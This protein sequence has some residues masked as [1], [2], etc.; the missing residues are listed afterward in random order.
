MAARSHIGIAICCLAASAALAFSAAGQALAAPSAT[1]VH[2]SRAVA[3][4]TAMT[5]AGAGAGTLT[6]SAGDASASGG[7][8]LALSSA[9]A[10]V[11]TLGAGGWQVQSSAPRTGWTTG[12]GAT[13]D[14]GQI[15]MPGFSTAGWLPVR[16]DDAGAVGTEVEALL[17]NGVC[18]DHPSLE[19]VN[20][21]ADDPASVF[22][23]NN[24]QRCFGAPMTS[25]GADTDPLFD[26]PWWFRTDFTSSLRP[27]QDAKLVINGVVGQADLWVNGTE[28]AT[29]ATVEGDYN[30]YTFDVTNL[31]RPG[32]NSLAFEMFP[33]NP[34]AMFTLDDVD[35]NQIPPDNNTGIQFPVELHV[36][37]AL[38]ISNSYVTQD[39]AADLS[40]ASLTVHADVT[41]NS[42]TTQA[43]LV[44]AQISPPGGG[45][46]ISVTR[47]VRL[48]G[49]ESRT[50]TFR[51]DR[52]R[53][54][55]IRHPQLW[56]PYQM[57]GQPL[58]TLSA[59]VSADG[60]LSDSAEPVPFG[61]R[62]VTTYLTAPSALEPSGARVFEINGVPF[63]YRAG[64]WSENLF[65]H[66]SATDLS[67][68]LALIKSMGLNGIRTE[69]KEMPQDF[70]NQMDRAGI[71]IDA[72]FQCCD[73]WQPSGS[74]RGVTAQEFHVM[75]QSSLTIGEQL[76]DHPSV[77]NFSWSDNQPINEQEVA[78]LD[79][80]NQAGFQEPIISSAEY[81]SSGILGPSGE[82]EGPYDW[83]PPNYWY[84]TT[85]SSNNG[86]DNDSTLTNVGGSFGFDSEQG[87][88][89]TVPT[90]DSIDRFMSPADQSALWQQP[91]AHQYH[92]N[93]ESTSGEHSGYSFGTLDNLDVA[94][95]NRYG[96]WSSLPQFVTEGQVQNYE[97]IRSQFEAYIDHWNNTPTPS[98]GTVYWQLNKGWPTL[99]WDL[100]NYDYDEAGSYFGAKK[101]NEELHVLYAY[102][103]GQVTIDNLSGVRQAGLTVQSKVYGLNGHVLDNQTA[104]GLALAPQAV[105]NGVLTPSVPETTKPP[106]PAKT[107]FVEL[108]L[109]QGNT[110]VDRNVYWLSTQP[111]VI[112]WNSTEGNP[113]ANNG[114]PLSQYAD[115]TGLKTLPT[116]SLQ[117][118]AGTTRAS[119]GDLTTT[120]TITNPS[121]NSAVAFFLRADVR[122]GSR[123]G[124]AKAGHNQVLPITWSDNDI[125]LWPG[126]SQTLTATYHSSLL[127]GSTPVV[128]LSGWNVPNQTAAAPH[129]R[130]A[131]IAVAAAATTQKVQNF[132]VADGTPGDKGS[133]QPGHGATPGSAIAPA[134]TGVTA[135]SLRLGYTTTT[136]HAGSGGPAWS[137]KSVTSSPGTTPSTSFTQGDDADTYTITVTNT[138]KKATDGT[139]PV[140]L[141]DVVDPN[142]AM[143]SIRGT[144]WTCDTSNDPT[145][146]CTETGGAG[147]GPAVLAPEQSYPPI[148]LTAAVPLPAGFGT[149]DSTSGLHV[150]NAVTVTGGSRSGPSASIASATPIV[151]VPDLTADNAIDGAFRQG[152]TGDQYQITV[153]NTGGG[154][155]SG[156][157]SSPITATITGLPTGET[158]R[159]LYGSGWSCSLT[160]I[161]T[162]VTEP[163]DTCYRTD[164][165]PG[166]NG[167]DP[168]I[169]VVVSVANNAP[170]TGNET[171]L[172]SGGGDASSPAS[173][174]TATT[175]LQAADLTAASAHSGNFAQ[176]D[177]A[178]N[179][180]LTVADVP[181][182]NSAA[183]G[184]STGLVTLTD[185]LP[186]GLAATAMSGQG[187]ACNV[188]AITCY[189]SDALAAG[190]AYPPITLTV[191]VAANAPATVTNSV[192]VSG[193]GMTAGANSSTSN[194]GQS[195]TDP[196]TITQSGP[197]GTPPTPPARPVLSV[198][199]NHSGSF[200]EGDAADTYT[201]AVPD[202]G[203][204]GPTSGMVVVTD[205]LPAGLTPT[206]MSGGG[207]TC[208][209]APATLPP[210]VAARRS[211][212]LNT[213]EPQPTC[214][215]FDAL[216]AGKSYPPITLT[217]AVAND[218]RPGVSNSV[219]VSGGG[220]SGIAVGTDPTNVAQVAQ[221]S[222]TSIDSA[223][224]IPY[225]PFIAGGAG[226][227]TYNITVAN[228][229]FGATSGPITLR[230][231]LPPGITARSESGTGWTC[232]V[233]TATCRTDPGVTLAAGAQSQLT[234]TVAVAADAPVSTQTLIQ[235]SG[236]GALAAAE[237]DENNHY[238][239]VTTG[240]AYIDPTYIVP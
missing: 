138:G 61:I 148:T 2:Q 227:D 167:E 119:G 68:Q 78:S 199:S 21:S 159:A 31:L 134:K 236:G 14:G 46:A 174:A 129:S 184:P 48:A 189:R 187:W 34:T 4:A 179:Y 85:H 154:P 27:G 77:L 197:A 219:S 50:V 23:S 120:V 45:Y 230:T 44:T 80:F 158:I 141:T 155:T 58:Y 201:L 28:V 57:G 108:V 126:E 194:G 5:M 160:A 195:G 100:Y 237:I 128:S 151:G 180:T 165:L 133:A 15:S 65:L 36:A 84:D 178:D 72:G 116:E 74:G 213:Y 24:M 66:Y 131:Q 142:I 75:Y 181:G 238:N 212:V 221:L 25:V 168:P 117:V 229:G 13:A 186:W 42:A 33:N 52:F 233:S 207:W 239:A 121:S 3:R 89:D 170:A 206:R 139:T 156:S 62:S 193:G 173:V 143:S 185:S 132:G 18:P 177:K 79:G 183:G 211:S 166:E 216:A 97:D 38:G 234:L 240:G 101:A 164:P 30:T 114:H 110:V 145:E 137:I 136:S 96:A 1:G 12:H 43:G 107:Y 208:S 127:G 69:G 147:G 209:L 220:N 175:I 225:A 82:K 222:V 60:G 192:T 9:G 191:S 35:W 39:D 198:T 214:Y 105:S 196:T 161:T 22:Y 8:K 29:E 40:S 113:Q 17:Q 93:Y 109:R 51:P 64:G 122:K 98:T 102:D 95:K 81:N 92:T 112:D 63:D 217:V 115:L 232:H 86:N 169:T 73:K 171:V 152:D 87:S 103:T 49:G 202:A 53:Q 124:T 144:G 135:R 94:I 41:N 224:G 67:D 215:R 157:A 162:R 70:Y 218:A 203:G 56:W 223:A 172:V 140:T 71:L 6:M 11:S 26:V 76:R 20:Q 125:T 235:A 228:D 205:T 91:D 118:A 176:G 59:S 16:A 47:S 210:T 19:P 83:V 123:D 188:A 54:L 150:T 163:A 226:Q 88:G 182:P 200:S 32:A 106:T 231:D 90:M 111:D 10:G 146:T 104:H 55:V 153:I 130:A 204:A 99:L 7:A 37:G 149:Q 190:S